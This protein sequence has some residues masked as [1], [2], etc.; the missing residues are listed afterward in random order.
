ML[1]T[2]GQA[3]R[4][5]LAAARRGKGIAG[6]HV[7]LCLDNPTDT[8]LERLAESGNVGAGN[9][10]ASASAGALPGYQGSGAQRGWPGEDVYR[11]SPWRAIAEMSI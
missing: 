7:D 11:A 4:G 2:P 1:R 9:G 5:W 3:G 6:R 8:T 10:C